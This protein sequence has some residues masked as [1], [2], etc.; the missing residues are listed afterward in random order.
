M[1]DQEFCKIETAISGEEIDKVEQLTHCSFT[2]RE[3][4]EYIEQ[5]FVIYGVGSSTSSGITITNV[6]IQLLKRQWWQMYKKGWHK[7]Q[8]LYNGKWWIKY[9]S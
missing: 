8:D 3:L 6:D 4:K 9:N 1:T 5:A 7:H 2:G